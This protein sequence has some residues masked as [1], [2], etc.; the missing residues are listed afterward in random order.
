MMNVSPDELVQG[1]CSKRRM[2]KLNVQM[3]YENDGIWPE[4]AASHCKKLN[5][6]GGKIAIFSQIWYRYRINRPQS[7]EHLEKG[8]LT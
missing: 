6:G 8:E 3:A 5:F 4:D 2:K 1:E 7:R